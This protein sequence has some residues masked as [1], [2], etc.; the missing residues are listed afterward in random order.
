MLPPLFLPL[1]AIAERRYLVPT[2]MAFSF[3]A[4]HASDGGND[5]EPGLLLK[6]SGEECEMNV[7][8]SLSELQRL[9]RVRSAPW[10]GGAIKIGSSA[11]APVWWS[12]DAGEVFIAAGNDDQTWAFGLRI[13]LAQFAELRAAIEEELALMTAAEG[14]S[15]SGRGI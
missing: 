4:A 13:T 1:A 10:D 15:V 3:C 14:R 5:D 2:S 9:E 11:N 7:C 6:I 12:C 8:L